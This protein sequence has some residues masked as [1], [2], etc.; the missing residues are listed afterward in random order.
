MNMPDPVATVDPLFTILAGAG[1]GAAAAAIINI[2][3]N[4][5]NNRAASK[6]ELRRMAYDAAVEEFKVYVDNART[7]AAKTGQEVQLPSLMQLVSF[8]LDL[9]NSRMSPKHFK[10]ALD[11]SREV[12]Q[13]V[14]Q[15]RK[16]P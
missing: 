14:A 6:R 10:N 2:V 1:V 16:A 3:G 15:T 12:A 5:L 13:Q 4:I 11:R 9:A 7:K 8:N